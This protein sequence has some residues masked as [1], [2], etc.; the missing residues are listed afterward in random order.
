MNIRIRFICI[1]AVYFIFYFQL[2]SQVSVSPY[3]GL[4][5]SKDNIQTNTII[6]FDNSLKSNYIIGLSL[7]T[8]ISDRFQINSSIDFSPFRNKGVSIAQIL[9]VPPDRVEYNVIRPKLIFSYNFIGNHYFG[10]G[11]SY[12][13]MNNYY[14]L[15]GENKTQKRDNYRYHSVSFEFNYLINKIYI[16]LEFSKSF[17]V[18]SEE[19]PVY[20]SI[21][22]FNLIIGYLFPLNK[23]DE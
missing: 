4:N 1:A 14:L 20:D 22:S 23:T 15:M 13:I 10:I 21:N 18:I 19:F 8:Q 16:G 11:Y 9:S 5:I 17:D 7:R 12:S 6:D 2:L 3:F